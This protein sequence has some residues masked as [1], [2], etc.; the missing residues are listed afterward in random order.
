MWNTLQ[1]D[2]SN[3]TILN[4]AFGGSTLP[5]VIR[6]V[7]D[8]ITPYQAKQIVIYCGE[9]D[10]ASSDSVTAQIVLDRFIKLFTLIRSKSENVNIVYV[11]MKPSP[12]RPKIRTKL[13][14]GNKLI[15]A[16][17]KTKSKTAFVNVYDLMIDKNGE[18][19]KELFLSDMLH[20][21]PNGYVI[22]KKAIE[23][24]LIK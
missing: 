9:N 24:Y 21:K 19:M 15:E 20:M 5:D 3:Y 1:S 16:F 4:R 12:S 22:W 17:L 6:Y 13:M 7:D 18:P 11:S 8:V 10:L 2:F 14:E 23:P